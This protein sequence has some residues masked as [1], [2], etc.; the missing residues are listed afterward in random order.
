MHHQYFKG[1]YGLY[2]TWWDRIMHTT[3]KDYDMRFKQ[4]SEE[5]M[6]LRNERKSHVV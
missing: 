5:T 2:F 6:Q 4:V 1:N 3:H